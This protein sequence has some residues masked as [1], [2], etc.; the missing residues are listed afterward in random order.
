MSNESKKRFQSFSEFWPFYLSQH[1]NRVCRWLHVTGTTLAV[2]WLVLSEG[3][4]GARVAVALGIG[5]GLAWLG[6]FVFEKNRP[7]TFQYPFYSF[8]GDIKMYFFV[9]MRKL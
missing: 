8:L 3:H 2:T 5:Y 6:H 1:Q 4:L 7:A 9:L